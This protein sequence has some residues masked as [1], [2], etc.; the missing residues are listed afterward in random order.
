MGL[1]DAFE[2][3][4]LIGTLKTVVSAAYPAVGVSVFQFLIGTLKTL[5]CSP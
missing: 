5:Q 1:L 4:F 3:Q 2:F